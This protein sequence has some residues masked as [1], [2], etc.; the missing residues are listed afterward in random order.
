VTAKFTTFLYAVARSAWLDWCRKE[1]RRRD[2]R[3]RYEQELEGQAGTRA[4]RPGTRLDIQQALDALP[5][6]LRVVVVLSIYQGLKY[7]EIAEALDIP[8]GTVKSRMHLAMA[9]LRE[10][11]HVTDG[12]KPR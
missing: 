5:D 7:A 2:F 10:H 1:G 6:K 8:E 9:Q 3:E 4:P 12:I 11:L